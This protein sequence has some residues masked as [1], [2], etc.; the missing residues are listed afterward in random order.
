MEEPPAKPELDDEIRGYYERTDE[1]SRLHSGLGLLE[2]LRTQE[3]LRRS[4]PP[5]PAQIADVGGG[6]GV[7]AAWLAKDGYFVTLIDPVPLHVEQARVA[8]GEQPGAPFAVLAGDARA[9][10]MDDASQE[11]VLLLGPIYHLTERADRVAALIEARRVVRV[12]GLVVVAAIS[13]IASVLDGVA[14]GLLGDPE[15][16][17]MTSR[18]LHDGQ[19]RAVEGRWFTTAYF[20]RP[21]ELRA[22]CVEAGLE[23]VE[24]VA[25]EGPAAVLPDLGDRMADARRASVVLESARLVEHEADVL[26]ATSHFLAIARQPD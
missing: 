21:D 6:A 11:V 13:R 1:G 3:I 17:A 14:R 10:P 7:H 22:E 5:A 23:V 2:F 12:G 16:R 20:H 25:V 9:M 15:F 4:L 18:E 19:H 8:A 26:G 24:L